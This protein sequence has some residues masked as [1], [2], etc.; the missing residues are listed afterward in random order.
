MINT[1]ISFYRILFARVPFYRLNKLIFLCSLSGLGIL[2]WESETISGEVSFLK[3]F[4]KS[5]LGGVVIDVGANEG[6]YSKLV[7]DINKAVTVYAF[8][9]HPKTFV[10]LSDAIRGENFHPINA[11]V[12]NAE[13]FLS[14]YDYEEKDGSKHASLYKD[15]IEN[16]HHAKAVEHKV[17]TCCLGEFAKSKNIQ[18]IDLLK[19]DAEGNELNVLRGLTEFI[20]SAKIEA[21]HFEFN[22]MNVCS[23]TFFRDFWDILPNYDFYRL[24]PTGMVKIERY[25]PLFCEI[26]AYQNIVAILKHQ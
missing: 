14:L 2:N 16:I 24:L 4:L 8:E 26:F 6:T 12:S 22:E 17:R 7:L 10:R 20:Q 5:R 11:A 18:K 19:I 13:G 9:P 1:M 21:I 3:S 25:S 23:R 15:V